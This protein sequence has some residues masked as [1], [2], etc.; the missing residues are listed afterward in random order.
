MQRAGITYQAYY[1]GRRLTAA[2]GHGPRSRFRTY[3]SEFVIFLMQIPRELGVSPSL[4]PLYPG[5][6]VGTEYVSLTPRMYLEEGLP[7][8]RRQLVS[9]MDLVVDAESF[10]LKSYGREL[11]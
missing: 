2:R 3:G 11:L 9:Q 7:Y 6:M 5:A 1:A 10:V 4:N 8:A